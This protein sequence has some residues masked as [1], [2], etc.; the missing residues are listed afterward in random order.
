MGLQDN[1]RLPRQEYTLRSCQ[2]HAQRHST[3][4]R[5]TEHQ[6]HVASV[7]WRRAT[8]SAS[9]PALNVEQL[10][11]HRRLELCAFANYY[12]CLI[13]AQ[14][15]TGQ[16][17]G[18]RMRRSRRR[19]LLCQLS[20]ITFAL[21]LFAQCPSASSARTGVEGPEALMASTKRDFGD[22]F[23]GEELEQ[24]FPVRNAG[25]KPLELAQKSTLGTRS[26]APN[27]LVRAAAWRPNEQLL[28]RT[29]SARPAAPS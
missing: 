27:Y 11:C 14:Y 4:S 5:S 23:A 16:N 22:V 28:A 1:R 13:V 9:V 21:S 7:S 12:S 18:S 25:N 20:L 19:S 15:L 6:S 3:L 24:N 17:R 2:L 26:S 8:W 29:V 10:S